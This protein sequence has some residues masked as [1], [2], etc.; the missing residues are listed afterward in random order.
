MHITKKSLKSKKHE[1]NKK[2]IQ[3]I[4]NTIYKLIFEEL[5]DVK[6]NSKAFR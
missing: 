4:I 6:L 3:N 5:H 2:S 1:S